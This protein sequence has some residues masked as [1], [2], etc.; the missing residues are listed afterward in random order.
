MSIL[1]ALM[2]NS[3]CDTR[4]ID[5][6]DWIIRVQQCCAIDEF[7]QTF[8]LVIICVQVLLNSIVLILRL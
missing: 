5:S 1:P 4:L 8:I 3:D 2:T 6:C 7:Q